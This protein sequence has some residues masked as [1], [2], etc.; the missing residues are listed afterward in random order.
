MGI[1]G[2]R[3]GDDFLVFGFGKAG[4]VLA[5]RTRKQRDIL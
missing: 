4:D 2:L 3:R 5:D 1:G